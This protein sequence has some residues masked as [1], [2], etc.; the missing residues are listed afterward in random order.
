MIY[1]FLA[2][3]F[4]ETE[5]VATADII[6]RAGLSVLLC[7]IGDRLVTGAHG[8]KIRADLTVNDCDFSDMDA[9]VLPGGMPGT[10]NLSKCDTITELLNRQNKNKKLIAAICAAPTILANL[11]ILKGKTATV[12][13]SFKEEIVKKG[14]IFSEDPVICENIITANGPDTA[15]EFGLLI[16]QY[17]CGDERRV[18]IENAL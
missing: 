5:A 14:A 3:G 13:P 15:I 9:V 11:G 4:E 2:D 6:R 8:I 12:Y 7:S 10:L 17:F 1:L 18:Q 16:V